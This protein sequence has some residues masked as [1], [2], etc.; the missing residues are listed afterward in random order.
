[1]GF[2]VKGLNSWG[3]RVWGPGFTVPDSGVRV[4]VIPFGVL[5][6]KVKGQR[7]RFRGLLWEGPTTVA[8]TGVWRKS[9]V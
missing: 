9:V 4:Q 3:F 6:T 5:K 1:M 2:R 7:C 8:H